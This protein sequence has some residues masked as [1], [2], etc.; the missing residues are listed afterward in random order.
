MIKIFYPIFELRKHIYVRKRFNDNRLIHYIL[1]YVAKIGKSV[2]ALET[3]LFSLGFHQG[4]DY[5]PSKSLFYLFIV[6]IYLYGMKTSFLSI[7]C[8]RRIRKLIRYQPSPWY[9]FRLVMVIFK[10]NNI[11]SI[12]YAI[13][14]IFLFIGFNRLN[15]ISIYFK[16]NVLYRYITINESS[17]DNFSQKIPVYE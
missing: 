12:T 3:N 9:Y 16:K 10:H 11:Y 6:A 2:C 13:Q 14:Y 5:N 7:S 8:K 1:G 17:C 15:L 4:C